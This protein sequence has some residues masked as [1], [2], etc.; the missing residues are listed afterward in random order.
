MI[1]W[2]HRLA[3]AVLV[4][5]CS[6]AQ[7]S[8]PD[9]KVI[10]DGAVPADAGPDARVGP[11]GAIAAGIV[12]N[13]V[14]AAGAP[15]WFEIANPTTVDV[16]L[17]DVYFSDDLTP[18]VTAGANVAFIPAGSHVSG[19]QYFVLDVDA[20]GVG[21]GLGKDEA[22]SL[23]R[24]AD[25]DHAASAGDTLLDSVDWLDGD[26][27]AAASFARLPDASGAFATTATPTRGGPNQ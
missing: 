25:G 21:F 23:W 5:A 12:I 4:T 15:D 24:D 1:T 7:D 20:A 13:E 6:H 14:V 19:H 3:C 10:I 17:S 18:A 27:P 26:A 11:D 22:L 9:A 8:T 16:D 2:S